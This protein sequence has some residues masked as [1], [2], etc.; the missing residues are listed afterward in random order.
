MAG[1]GTRGSASIVRKQ[2]SKAVGP[3]PIGFQPLA[4][5]DLSPDV[6]SPLNKPAAEMKRSG[7]LD[8]G[9]PML[10]YSSSFPASDIS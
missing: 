6:N 8:C 2:E 3:R 9:L 1:G 4:E 5:L 7:C 10:M